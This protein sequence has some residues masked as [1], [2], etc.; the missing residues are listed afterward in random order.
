[1]TASTSPF[2]GAETEYAGFW[3]RLWAWV[4]DTVLLS[5]VIVP[6]ELM[7]ILGKED[8]PVAYIASWRFILEG[9]F[10]AVVIIVFWIT[11]LATPGKM[12]IHAKIVDERT[13]D[14]PTNGQLI[15]R[16]FA[17]ALSALPLFLGF[18][19]IAFDSKKQGWHDKLARTVVVKPRFRGKEAVRPERPAVEVTLLE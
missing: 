8:A 4:I 6:L 15:G 18:L 11:K 2:Y 3:S 10:P 13:I 5:I 17:M 14:R 9:V 16:Y 7:L 1:M 12:A 19:W